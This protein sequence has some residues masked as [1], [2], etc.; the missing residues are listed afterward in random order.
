MPTGQAAIESYLAACNVSDPQSRRKL[1][2]QALTEDALIAYPATEAQGWDD[3]S[4]A[5]ARIH[6]QFPGVRFVL[7]GAVEEHHG[8]LRARWRIIEPDGTTRL[9]GEDVAE[10]ARDGRLTRVIGFYD[11]LAPQG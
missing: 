5:I 8:W 3:V 9:E 1:L 4:A 2:E 11:P 7:T 6:E 10:V